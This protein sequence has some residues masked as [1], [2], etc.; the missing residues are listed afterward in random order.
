MI[1]FKKKRAIVLLPC[2]ILVCILVLDIFIKP[3]FRQ[4]TIQDDYKKLQ[5]DFEQI[6]NILINYDYP[7][8]YVERSNI[9]SDDREQTI[10]SIVSIE[11]LNSPSG[12]TLEKAGY[13]E[14]EKTNGGIYFCKYYD[15]DRIRGVMYYP[16]GFQ[17]EFNE[18]VTKSEGISKNWYYF[19]Q[20]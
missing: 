18:L 13:R 9:I 15:I 11:L 16:N 12:A 2:L 3:V 5:S 1:K 17:V 6:A 8:I 19:E 14:F 4:M 7:F 10:N 20:E